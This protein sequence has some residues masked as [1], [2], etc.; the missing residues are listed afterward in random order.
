MTLII[1]NN[2]QWP[3]R[4]WCPCMVLP[5]HP[6]SSADEDGVAMS[7]RKIRL[8]VDSFGTSIVCFIVIRHRRRVDAKSLLVLLF[9]FCTNWYSVLCCVVTSVTIVLVWNSNFY[10]TLFDQIITPHNCIFKIFNGKIVV[11]LPTI[12]YQRLRQMQQPQL[13]QSPRMMTSKCCNRTIP[14]PMMVWQ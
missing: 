9:S 11:V 8:L 12:Q 4:W 13:H 14:L 10:A 7:P 5:S 6:L 2:G 1:F 3:Q